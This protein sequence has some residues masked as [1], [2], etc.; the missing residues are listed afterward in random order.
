MNLILSEIY[1]IFYLFNFFL[2]APHGLRDFSS[3]TRDRTQTMAVK[4]KF[5]AH[6][7][8][9]N[10][11]KFTLKSK[12]FSNYKIS[13]IIFTKLYIS[14]FIFVILLKVLIELKKHL[15][16]FCFIVY[17]LIGTIFDLF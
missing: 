9:G 3:M 1:F 7:L 13:T 6:G 5:L 4:A 15:K 11:L 12:A 10:S 2:A 17:I 14:S 16:I 8:Q